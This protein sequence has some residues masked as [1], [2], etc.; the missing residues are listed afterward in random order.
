MQRLRFPCADEQTFTTAAIINTLSSGSANEG[1]VEIQ[2]WNG[3]W[4]A[5]CGQDFGDAAAAAVCRMQ[6]YSGGTA[7]T[8]H[9]F[10]LGSLPVGVFS[11]SCSGNE[12]NLHACKL[13]TMGN[14]SD[15]VAAVRCTGA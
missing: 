7:L 1:R 6:G 4:I 3:T 13:T 5:V 12:T 2:L 15:S 14:C 11:A 10:G 8:E 9:A